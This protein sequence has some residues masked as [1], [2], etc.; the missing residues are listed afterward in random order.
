[1]ADGQAHVVGGQRIG[2]VDDDLAGQVAGS[3]QRCRS[4]CK[5]SGEHDR[6][7]ARGGARGEDGFGAGVGGCDLCRLGAIFRRHADLMAGAGELFDE[8]RAHVAGAENC[9]LHDLSAW[10]CSAL[11]AMKWTV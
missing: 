2:D 1:V 9:D 3:L 10:L 4:V 6:V 7:G 8:C 11:A 5:G